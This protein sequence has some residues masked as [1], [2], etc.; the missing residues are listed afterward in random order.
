MAEMAAFVETTGADR[1]DP[2]T[3]AAIIGTLV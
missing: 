3:V 1:Y 2:E